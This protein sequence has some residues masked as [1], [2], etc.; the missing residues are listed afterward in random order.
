MDIESQHEPTDAQAER[1]SDAAYFE[2]LAAGLNEKQKTVVKMHL[3][4]GVAFRDIGK[5][6][7]M[8]GQ[9]AQYHLRRAMARLKKK[10]GHLKYETV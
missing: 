3:G 2:E 5:Q 6:L 1:N 4:E 8:S 9:G 10:V 7:D